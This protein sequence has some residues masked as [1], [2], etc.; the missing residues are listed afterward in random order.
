MSNKRIQKYRAIM[1]SRGKR[2]ENRYVCFACKVIHDKG[3][4]YTFE[5]E[6]YCFCDYCKSLYKPGKMKKSVYSMS[7]P[8][9]SCRRK[10]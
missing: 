7:V 4:K 6:D 1:H 5:D 9:E 3:W 8:F 2:I 10:H